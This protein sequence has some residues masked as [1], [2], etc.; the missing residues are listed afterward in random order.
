MITPRR[1]EIPRPGS[2]QTARTRFHRRYASTSLPRTEKSRLD[3]MELARGGSVSHPPVLL[4]IGL[5]RVQHRFD[6]R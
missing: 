2:S 4:G 3:P 6:A 5:E 1:I